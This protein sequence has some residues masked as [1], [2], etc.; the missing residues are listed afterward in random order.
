M[1]LPTLPE[2]VLE[3]LSTPEYFDKLET[4]ELI[5]LVQWM[6]STATP[7]IPLNEVPWLQEI[8][9]SNVKTLILTLLDQLI[10][11]RQLADEF[12]ALNEEH[13]LL[14]KRYKSRMENSF[15]VVTTLVLTF[16]TLIFGAVFSPQIDGIARDIYDMF[17]NILVIG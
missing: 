3:R 10:E 2:E 4:P 17:V 12:C 1:T 16:L 8:Y 9:L 13:N 11:E 6:K 15:G 14:K 7:Q 5:K